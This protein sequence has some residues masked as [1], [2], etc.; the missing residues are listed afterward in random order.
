LAHNILIWSRRW[1]AIDAPRFAKYEA[2]RLVRDLFHIHGLLEFAEA[3]KT[4]RITRNQ[5]AP[6]V[7]EMASA[8]SRHLKEMAMRRPGAMPS[9][10]VMVSLMDACPDRSEQ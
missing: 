7:R 9:L 1:L 3:G 2:L 8:L 10:K 4:L 6:Y 5:V